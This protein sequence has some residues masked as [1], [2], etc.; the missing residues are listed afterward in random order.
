MNNH[1]RLARD[2][3]LDPARK[4]AELLAFL[5]LTPGMRVAELGALTGYTTELLARAVGPSG[6]VFAEN[7]HTVLERFAARP[8]AERLARPVNACVLAVDRELDDPLPAHASELDLVLINV[9]YHDAVWLKAD[10]DQM[11]R[12]VFRA[13]RPGGRYVVV[14]SSARPHSGLAD[15]LRLHRIDEALV[16][17]EVERAGF[18]LAAESTFLRNPKDPRDWNSASLDPRH[19]RGSNDCFVH[20]YEKPASVQTSG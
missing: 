16:R 18:R 1:E 5:A 13:L 19:P 12:A 15:S 3:A 7:V 2:I 6:V 10:R 20:G 4:P 9:F 8:L 11:N 14:D 17:T